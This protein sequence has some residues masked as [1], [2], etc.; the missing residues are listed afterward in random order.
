[1]NASIAAFFYCSGNWSG[2]LR[3]PQQSPIEARLLRRS[4]IGACFFSNLSEFFSN[5][6][7]DNRRNRRGMSSSIAALFSIAAHRSRGAPQF[8]HFYTV[9]VN[10]T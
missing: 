5:A 10:M 8:E 2:E 4:S 1:M 9:P 3:T 6:A 7:I